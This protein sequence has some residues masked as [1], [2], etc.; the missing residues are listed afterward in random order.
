[1]YDRSPNVYR[2][3]LHRKAIVIIKDSIISAD[4]YKAGLL[5]VWKNCVN[6]L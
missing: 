1:M 3:R 2:K 4:I 5:I 6:I